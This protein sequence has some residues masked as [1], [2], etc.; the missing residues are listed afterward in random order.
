MW[1]WNIF[2]LFISIT[3]VFFII[4]TNNNRLRLTS[5]SPNP[6]YESY[7]S[8]VAV[9]DKQSSENQQYTTSPSISFTKKT[10]SHPKS[11]QNNQLLVKD[12]QQYNSSEIMLKESSVLHINNKNNQ[13]STPIQH[14]QESTPIQH[15]QE[16]THP[17]S[18]LVKYAEETVLEQQYPKDNGPVAEKVCLSCLTGF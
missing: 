2:L 4:W 13:E 9:A 16:S 15:Y 12:N 6:V 11:I 17:F 14:Y 18:K 8:Y 7:S 5:F 10:V 1:Y 3:V